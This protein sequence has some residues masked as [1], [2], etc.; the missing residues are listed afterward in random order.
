MGGAI[1]QQ[2]ALQSPQKL[3]GL[4]LVGTGV[5]L[6]VH[7][8]ILEATSDPTRSE[9]AVDMIIDW[10]FSESAPERLVELA[11]RRMLEV[12]L[13]V[14]HDDFV[15]CNNFDVME[16]VSEIKLPALVICGESD[17]LT[18]MKYSQFLIDQLGRASLERVPEAGHMVML[19]KPELVAEAIAKFSA[20]ID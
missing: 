13:N 16:R 4:I 12:D 7:P 19:E 10:S 8:T 5:R 17:R 1:A 6:R 15:A 9:E 3:S 20:E 18:P 11:H 2:F 14:I